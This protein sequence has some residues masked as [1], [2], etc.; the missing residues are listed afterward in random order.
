MKPLVLTLSTALLFT[1]C[2]APSPMVIT[3]EVKVMV[4]VPCPKPPAR[5]KLLLPTDTLPPTADDRAKA[6]AIKAT[7]AFLVLHVE[8]LE[9]ILDGYRIG[10]TH[11]ADTDKRNGA[12]QLP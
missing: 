4:P 6:A 11:A 5:A 7:I 1:A 8:R 2:K 10:D 9:T 3:K 12:K